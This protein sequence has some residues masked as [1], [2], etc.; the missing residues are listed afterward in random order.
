MNTTQNI[1][2]LNE[3]DVEHFYRSN[4]ERETNERFVS[5]HNTDGYIEFSHVR[6]LLEVKFNAQLDTLEGRA[7]VIA[8]AIYY[9]KA[10]RAK[11]QSPNIFLI[12]DKTHF[13]I[14][15]TSSIEHYIE[16][17]FDWSKPASTPDEALKTAIKLDTTL[18][19]FVD[20]LQH[21][22]FKALVAECKR[23]THKQSTKIKAD[24]KN[25]HEMFI[26]WR[27][28]VIKEKSQDINTMID[29]FYAI[30]CHD[31]NEKVFT[32]P[33]KK[34]T[35]M[36]STTHNNQPI[37]KEIK[38]DLTAMAGFFSRYQ[39]GYA[40]S[41]IDTLMACRDRLID[42]EKRRRKGEYYTPADW[43]SEAHKLLSTTLEPNSPESE[44]WYDPCCAV[45]NLTRDE[46]FSNLILSTLEQADIDAIGREVY[47]AGAIV[48]Q[49]DFLNSDLPPHVE[50]YL[51]EAANAGKRIIFLMNPPYATAKSGA[52]SSSKAGVAISKTN[53]AMKAVGLGSA[54]QQLYAQFIFKADMI[55]TQ[56]G[57]TKKT[58]ALFSPKLFMTSSSFAAFRS[59]F[60]TKYA[61][62]A[63]FMFKASEFADVKDTWG[64]SFTIWS[65]GATEHNK[66]LHIIIKEKSEYLIRDIGV[67]SLQTAYG[68]EASVWV[69]TPTKGLKTYDTPQLTSGLNIVQDGIGSMAKEALLYMHN[70]ANNIQHSAQLVGLYSTSFASAHGLS[71]ISGESWRRSIALFSARKLSNDTW[72]THNDEYFAP[73]T[74]LESY[75]DWVDDCHI[76]A[77]L[78]TANNMTSMRN[79]DYK[80]KKWNINNHFFWLNRQDALTIYDT[81]ETTPLFRDCK[82]SAH[83]PYFASILPTLKLSPLALEI[84]SDL[85]VLFKDTIAHR[86]GLDTHLHLLS[87]DAGVYQLKTLW[88]TDP[89]WELIKEKHRRLA[90]QLAVGV[91]TYGFLK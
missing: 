88:A 85:N 80:D 72:A 77:L 38:I 14:L 31:E 41:E 51:T 63:G 89:R 16:K 50:T 56:F 33:Q 74:E 52:N 68:R 39:R 47:N 25:I 81:R 75:T 2:L 30:V 87:W 58:I 10:F 66:D 61:Y 22:C 35:I 40:P 79:I 32:H 27:R 44:V 62:Q 13:F 73:N 70:N 37:T 64:I 71:V 7:N 76:Y 19:I 15:N 36:F 12:G 91:Y 69:R 67:K 86:T 84:V 1:L 6:L 11:G 26:S 83:N 24:T 46:T 34:N 55:A 54:S 57:F 18:N 60:Y 59:F 82:A 49:H 9:F 17:D 20:S 3:K 45:G 78:H 90:T 5:P 29:I 65:E 28:N 43:A 8:Q 23:S 48:F 53:Q 42:D 21:D 4:I